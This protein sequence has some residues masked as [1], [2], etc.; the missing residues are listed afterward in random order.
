VDRPAFIGSLA[1][2]LLA[3][4]LAAEAQTVTPIPKIGVIYFDQ[5][6]VRTPASYVFWEPMGKLG[7]VEGQNVLV[8]RRT[9]AGDWSRIA[10]L[11]AE[12]VRL[13]VDVF[14][15]AGEVTAQ[16]IQRVTRTIPICA[17]AGDFQSAGLV[18]NLARPDQ[19]VTGVQ[20]VQ[21]ELTGK[22]L[23]ILKEVV[24]KLARVGVLLSEQRHPSTVALLRNA[25]DSA[26]LLGLQVQVAEAPRPEDFDRAFA[27][28]TGAHVRGLVVVSNPYMY[29]H[30]SLVVDSA[31]KTRIA[32]IYTDRIWVQ[33]GGLMSY[34]VTETEIQRRLAECADKILRGG[35]WFRLGEGPYPWEQLGEGLIGT[36]LRPP[37]R[38]RVPIAV[39][40]NHGPGTF[41]AS[42]LDRSPT[43]PRHSRHGDLAGP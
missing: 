31:A 18:K 8:E 26:R 5:P 4:P 3:A 9:A 22:R 15:V 37:G 41:I 27:A 10:P 14:L 28:L 7:W 20:S 30:R 21:I 19:N 40:P 16:Y 23:G 38:A 13:Q 1:S 17:Y 11:A 25:E 42:P 39:L 33:A 43:P 24:P 12:L 29:R 2:G 36:R 6:P 32:T 35:F 34:G